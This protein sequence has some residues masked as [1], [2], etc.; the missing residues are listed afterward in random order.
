MLIKCDGPP[1]P[2]PC[3]RYDPSRVDP[4]DVVRPLRRGRPR[5]RAGSGASPYNAIASTSRSADES[6]GLDR[7]E[8]AAW[9]FRSWL[10]DGV[11]RPDGSPPSTSTG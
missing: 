7:Y 11:V 5:E 8:N 4:D 1:G 10:D 2:V 3:N 9:I 6:T